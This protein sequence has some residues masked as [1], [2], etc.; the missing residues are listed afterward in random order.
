MAKAT[1]ESIRT[2]SDKL[3]NRWT[4]EFAGKPRHTR[5]LKELE[6]IIEKAAVLAKKAKQLK[7]EKGAE[8]EK[9]VR[10]RLELYVKERDAIAEAQFE[11]PE[12]GEIHQQGQAVE[13][14]LA[15]WRRHFAGRD[16]RSRDLGLLDGAIAR[17]G[18]ALARLDELKEMPEVKKDKLGDLFGQLELMKDERS[19]I[20]KLRRQM[21]PAD[22]AVSLL[23]EAQSALDRYRVSFAGQART[24]VRVETLDTIIAS[25]EGCREALVEAGEEQAQNL[26]VLDQNL[27]A[28]RNERKLIVEAHDKV[29]VRDRTNHLGQAANQM[30][31]LYQQHF[32]GQQR[33]TRDLKLLS[34]ICDR[35]TE[36]AIQM[37]EHDATHAET[38]NRK[39]LPVV[40]DRLRRYEAEWVE[41]MKAK[42]QA[43]E[44]QAARGQAP[45]KPA[46]A[47]AAPSQPA[48]QGPL[49]G[50][51]PVQVGPQIGLTGAPSQAAK[52]KGNPLDGL[53]KVNP[54][55]D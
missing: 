51:P 39:N 7:G 24:T 1:I 13:R 31:Q 2:L 19:E 35:L 27:G 43:A 4:R 30:F 47:A 45:E 28:Y 18:A 5:D 10:E 12:I 37:A 41:I 46:Q 11:R 55:K 44:Q 14:S 29:E 49:A 52:P 25:L 48:P 21:T 38:L 8:V 3:N 50:R 54:K 42:T 15:V 17:L 23:A 26:A 33:V 20:E 6:H 9:V 22:R 34:D 16:R 36:I 53:I 40:E 32:A